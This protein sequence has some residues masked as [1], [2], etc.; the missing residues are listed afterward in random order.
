MSTEQNKEC[1]H[2]AI[3]PN[4]KCLDCGKENLWTADKNIEKWDMEKEFSLL[5]SDEGG[6]II[7]D[8]YPTDRVKVISFIHLSNQKIIE[9]A[10]ERVEN[11]RCFV[12]NDDRAPKD[13]IKEVKNI[14]NFL[15][16]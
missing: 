4:G 10:I 7:D 6:I 15:L 12:G 11:V 5:L 16:K 8:I 9:Q 1:E 3:S 2:D 14:L 13:I